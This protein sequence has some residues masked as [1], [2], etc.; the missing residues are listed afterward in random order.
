MKNIA[1]LICALFIISSAFGQT[2]TFSKKDWK[3]FNTSLTENLNAAKTFY[4]G[5]I[6]YQNIDE[7]NGMPTTKVVLPHASRNFIETAGFSSWNVYQ[8]ETNE[9]AKTFFKE[10]KTSLSVPDIYEVVH[11]ESAVY[12]SAKKDKGL[13]SSAELEVSDNSVSIFFSPPFEVE[14]PWE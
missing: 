4:K 14:I 6:D 9:E 8:F 11:E 7:E 13:N 3:S 10:L 2:K 5:Q 1:I 12:I